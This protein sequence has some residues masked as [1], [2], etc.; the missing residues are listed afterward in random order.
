MSG[1][2]RYRNDLNERPSSDAFPGEAANSARGD[3]RLMLP[4]PEPVGPAPTV[5]PSSPLSESPDVGG[6]GVSR[7]GSECRL[8]GVPVIGEQTDQETERDQR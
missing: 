6:E 5:G 3:G 4:V 1:R 8:L 7:T 2:L